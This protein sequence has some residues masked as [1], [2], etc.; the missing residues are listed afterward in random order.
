MKKC[1]SFLLVAALLPVLVQ[2]QSDE[3]TPLPFSV[4]IG[5]QAAQVK[6]KGADAVHATI[7][8][9]V[10]ADAAIELGTKGGEMAI[11]NVNAADEKGAPAQGATPAV[12]IIQ[13]GTKTSLD[14]TMDGKKLAPGNYLMAIVAEG[15]TASVFLKVQ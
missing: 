14:K 8:K 2:A 11:I 4:T 7:E 3:H 9:P 15:K 1:L 12:I 13:N 10:A 6:G 5:G